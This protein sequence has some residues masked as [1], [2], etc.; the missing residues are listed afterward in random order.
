MRVTRA[1]DAVAE[2][3][4]ARTDETEEQDAAALARD[5]RRAAILLRLDARRTPAP[6]R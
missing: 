2:P 1:A 4:V 6:R 5:F 3:V